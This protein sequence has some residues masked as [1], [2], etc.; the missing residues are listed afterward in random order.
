[1]WGWMDG[2]NLEKWR[3]RSAE[4]YELQGEETT[5]LRAAQTDVKQRSNEAISGKCMPEHFWRLMMRYFE[6]IVHISRNTP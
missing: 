4:K 2:L 1:M 6:H 3:L 5:Q